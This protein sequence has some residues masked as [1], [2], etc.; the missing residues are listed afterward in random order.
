MKLSTKVIDVGLTDT[1][2][3]N[4]RMNGSYTKIGFPSG[5]PIGGTDT[6]KTDR[7]NMIDV[8]TNAAMLHFGIKTKN[9]IKRWPFME[10]AFEENKS[11]VKELLKNAAQRVYEGKMTPKSA[12]GVIGEDM[13]NKVKSEMRN[14]STPKEED[15]TIKRKKGASNPT[16]HT[17]QMVNTVTH[18]EVVK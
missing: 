13:V 10:N 7:K 17:G 8:A 16:I 2:K 18:V 11:R 9:G 4:K 5:E 14:I 6:G 3:A 12:L 1:Q 15:E